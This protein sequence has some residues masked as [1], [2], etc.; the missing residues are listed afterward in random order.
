MWQQDMSLS[1]F[2]WPL[3]RSQ[4]LASCVGMVTSSE[5]AHDC[6][7]ND[8]I[9]AVGK[10]TYLAILMNSTQW[11]CAVPGDLGL[12]HQIEHERP[13]L[14]KCGRILRSHWLPPTQQSG[15]SWLHARCSWAEF[16]GRTALCSC[17]CQKAFQSTP[18]C[19]VCSHTFRWFGLI[20][21]TVPASKRLGFQNSNCY[22]LGS[23]NF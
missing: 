21:L 8:A 18:Y 1:F 23:A 2:F 7:Y 4:C 19:V 9:L 10:I 16:F 15:W 14:W 20:L 22:F 17:A 12:Q 13:R 5:E 3:L 6:E 11:T